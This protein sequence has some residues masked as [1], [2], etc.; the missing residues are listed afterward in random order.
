MA[1]PSPHTQLDQHQRLRVSDQCGYARWRLSP[2][3]L[4]GY[5]VFVVHDE[6]IDRVFRDI[7]RFDKAVLLPV[8]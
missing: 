7:S 5:Y 2:L 4:C 1:L 6:L 8:D 3:I